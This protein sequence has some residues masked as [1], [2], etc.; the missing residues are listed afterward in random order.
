MV[1]RTQAMDC[2]MEMRALWTRCLFQ[3]WLLVTSR[4]QLAAA[5][6]EITR[7]RERLGKVHNSLWGMRKADLIEVAATELGIQRNRAAK[8]TVVELRERIR[9]GR[10]E[11][12]PL[13]PLFVNPPN[14]ARMTKEQL[15]T[16]C[17]RRGLPTEDMTRG[18]M[19]VMI[20]DDVDFR[21]ERA[22]RLE[23]G[24]DEDEDPSSSESQS[25]QRK[26]NQT[27]A[28]PDWY[29]MDLDAGQT[30]SSA[31]TT[32]IGSSSAAPPLPTAK[33]RPKGRG[34]N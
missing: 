16:D 11:I 10:V 14:L 6:G 31:S 30:P 20:R 19:I 21:A 7:L 25:P 26:R 34:R 4:T 33:T 24:L 8:M 5:E 28:D 22:R 29:E 2:A 3:G 17:E 12:G 9:A 32:Q 1:F 13:D 23:A 18:A 27:H 15:Q